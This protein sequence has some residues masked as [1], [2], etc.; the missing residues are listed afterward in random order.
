[1]AN[2][3]K[4]FI[5]DKA[6]AQRSRLNTHFVKTLGRNIHESTTVRH[7]FY[8]KIGSPLRHLNLNVTHEVDLSHEIKL[9]QESVA[10]LQRRVDAIE[11]SYK[12]AKARL[13]D[14]KAWLR[15]LRRVRS[16]FQTSETTEEQLIHQLFF[17]EEFC[18]QGK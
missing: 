14:A 5:G 16:Q 17:V 15:D 8:D 12:D 11:P 4:K 7:A 1:M 10:D 6:N 3:Y 9:A 2:K 18:N 13:N